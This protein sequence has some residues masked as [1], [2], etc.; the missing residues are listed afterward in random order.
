MLMEF[1]VENF[2][3]IGEMQTINLKSGRARGKAD[4]LLKVN[5]KN[6]LK[7]SSIYGANG[8]GKSN[9]IKAMHFCK[10]VISNGFLNN[11]FMSVN[12]SDDSWK[13]KPTKFVYTIIVDKKIYEYGFILTCFNE[14]IIKEWLIEKNTRSVKVVFIRDFVDDKFNIDI[15]TKNVEINNRIQIYFSDS[16]KEENMLFLQE[17]NSK[18][19]DLY[20]AEP[21]IRFLR[22]I[23]NWFSDKLKFVYPNNN[24]D[25]GRY[26]FLN[27]PENNERLYNCLKELDIPINKMKYVDISIE[28][29]FKDVSQNIVEKLESDIKEMYKQKDNQ[30][31]GEL[32]VTL[33]L[34]D[35]YYLIETN[36][37]GI[38]NIKTVQFYHGNLGD[39]RFKEESDGTKRILEL[40]EIITSP[41][42]DVVYI[43]DE[44]DRSLHPL[45][46][47]KLIN[48]YLNPEEQNNNQLIISTHES[49]LLNLKTLRK[50]EIYFVTNRK[51]ES[52]FVRLDD[53]VSGAPRADLNIEL[54]YL[55]GRYNAIPKVMLYEDI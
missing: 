43:V 23:Y 32:S 27:Y 24:C 29:A 9:V 44:I 14:K 19:G 45:L 8:A 12:K 52:E 39:Y 10:T 31:D 15:K 38:K 42:K 13:N 34:D 25:L 20:D 5:R 6:I 26:S 51:G 48:M 49:R 55:N 46:T 3:S 17:I 37:E 41:E 53:Y 11:K 21:S 35:N 47:E 2:A 30:E 54:G 36:M 33:R 18:K 22:N 50:D 40:L 28:Q 1:S 4:H 16:S 7:F